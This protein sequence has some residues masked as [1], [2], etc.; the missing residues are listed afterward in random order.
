MQAVVL[1]LDEEVSLAE[2]LVIPHGQVLGLDDA[3]AQQELRKL[4]SDASRQADQPFAMLGEDLL[5]DPG[6]V[7]I[8]LEVRAR[9]EPQ[10]VTKADAVAG[11]QRQV[12]GIPLVARCA[13]ARRP[14]GSLAG[15]DVR[16]DSH[17]RQDS[18]CLGL[19]Q[20]LDGSKQIAVIGQSH[21]GHAQRL[22]PVD[23]VGNLALAVEQA[24]MAVTMKMHEG[25]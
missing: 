18:G 9:R 6:L 3:I 8:S 23:Q 25:L 22:D 13:R 19:A 2:C 5:V 17:D 24:V 21:C 10:Q 14:I 4:G 1:H 7:V 15:G 11:Q 12:V 16:F 20:E